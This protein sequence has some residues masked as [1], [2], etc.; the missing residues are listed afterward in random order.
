MVWKPIQNVVDIEMGHVCYCNGSNNN[1]S[2]NII[3]LYVSANF[4]IFLRHRSFVRPFYRVHPDTSNFTPFL[5]QKT[6]LLC[7]KSFSFLTLGPK[8]Y[9]KDLK[10][11]LKVVFNPM[12]NSLVIRK[13]GVICKENCAAYQ[14]T[15]WAFFKVVLSSLYLH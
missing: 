9:L 13:Y 5:C 4:I 8:Q 11:M 7:Q 1:T 10:I 3:V 14:K 12:W 15:L 2:H 6:P